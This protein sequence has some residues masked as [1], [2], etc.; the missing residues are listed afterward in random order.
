MNA[1]TS[2]NNRQKDLFKEKQEYPALLNKNYGLGLLVEIM[3]P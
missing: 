1:T 3:G 2:N